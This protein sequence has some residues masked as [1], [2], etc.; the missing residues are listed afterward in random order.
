MQTWHI[1]TQPP[2]LNFHIFV[3]IKSDL[4]QLSPM[5]IE[6]LLNNGMTLWNIN[7][8]DPLWQ[9]DD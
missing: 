5:D 3:S 1:N 7:D 8:A 6:R 2:R 4:K 9:N